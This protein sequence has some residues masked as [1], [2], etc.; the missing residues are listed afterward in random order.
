MVKTEAQLQNMIENEST[1][2]K[3]YGIRTNSGKY[4]V[5]RVPK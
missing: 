1:S 2:G 4:K 3:K 5:M